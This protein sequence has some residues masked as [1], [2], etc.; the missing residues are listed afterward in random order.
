MRRPFMLVLVAGLIA[1]GAWF[2]KTFQLDGLDKIS[3][4]PKSAASGSGLGN[5]GLG[6]G[7]YASVPVRE[8]GAV[9]IASF[10][11][12]VLGK[13][14]LSNQPVMEILADAVRKFDV[15]AIQ[16]IRSVTDDIVPRFIELINS[17]GR[18]YDFVIGPRLGRTNSKE[19]Y[20]FIYDAQTIE[21][22]RGAVY[23]VDDRDDLLHREPLVASFR[24]RGPPPEQAFTFTLINIH[25]D[26][27]EV[28][29]EVNALAAVYRAVRNDGRGEDDVMLLGDLNADE[30]KFGLL[31]Q[32][33]NLAWVISGVPTN[34]R[35]DKTYDNI[36]FNRLATTEFSGRAGVLDLMRE[37]NLTQAQALTVSDHLPVWAEFGTYEGGAP[38]RIAGRPEVTPR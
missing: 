20:A 8:A 22:D 25:T 18:H 5:G 30:R 10:N 2:F 26:P 34:T 13:E 9:R 38:G 35:G 37:Y 17:S 16:E 3:V 11:I 27:D 29:T 21:V 31:K 12:Q 15:V 7:H 36:L 23:T 33:P 1:G 32:L 14:K 19:Q 24:V 28:D 4:R 6:E